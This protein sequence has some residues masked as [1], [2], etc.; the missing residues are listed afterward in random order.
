MNVWIDSDAGFDDLWAVLVARALGLEIDGLS[1]VFGNSSISQV[2]RNATSA[3]E[4]FGWD[5][6][7]FKGAAAALLGTAETAERVL[8]AG[9]MRSRGLRLP[10]TTGEDGREHAFEAMVAWLQAGRR[11]RILALGPLTNLAALA[12]ARPDLADRIERIVWMGGGIGAGNHTPAAEFNA[13]ADPEALAALLA[14]R[15]PITL[16]ELDACRRV[17][18]DASDLRAL[19][20]VRG[21]NAA[22]LG[23]LA[24]GYLDI[25]LER[26]RESMAI[27]DPVAVVALARPEYFSIDDARVEVV[28]SGS[29]RGRTVADFRAPG[30]ECNASVATDPRPAAVKRACMEALLEACDR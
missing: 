2:A 19:L 9:G 14:R 27:Y 13:C 5:F 25:A 23:D 8:G 10:G 16:V 6:P 18:F 30:A 24:G 3:S 15:L 17:R 22:L 21:R 11:R 7:I 20:R 1:L 28:L 12:I 26:G 4:V 29:E